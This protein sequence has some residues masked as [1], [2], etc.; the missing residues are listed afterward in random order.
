MKTTSLR[1]LLF[2]T[3]LAV[4][5]APREAAAQLELKMSVKFILNSSGTRPPGGNLFTDDDVRRAFTNANNLLDTF[6]R[7][8]RFRITEIVDIA[9]HSEAYDV[10]V[11]TASEIIKAAVDSNSTAF[12]WRNGAANMYI[13]ND[14][15]GGSA[16]SGMVVVSHKGG[17]KTIL[18]ESGHHFGLCHTQGCGCQN[19][20]DCPLTSDGISDTLPDRECCGWRSRRSPGCRLRPPG[21]ARSGSP[22]AGPRLPRGRRQGRRHGRRQEEESDA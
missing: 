15:S 17:Y 5:I 3:A 6:G 22:G 4:L 10:D 2:F 18:H 12:G 14:S 8:Y 16:F 1:C 7:G 13:N 11:K 19:C 9:G 20:T 21:R